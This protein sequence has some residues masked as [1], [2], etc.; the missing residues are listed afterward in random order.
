MMLDIANP[1]SW[2]AS[3]TPALFGIVFC[4]L[5]G[6]F[7]PPLR[8]IALLIVSVLMQS[9]VNY[10]NDYYDFIKGTDTTESNLEKDDAVLVYNHINPK[11]VLTVAIVLLAA[12]AAIGIAAA[13]GSGPLPYVIGVIGGLTVIFYSG[14]KTPISYLPLGE[15]LSGLVMG[16]G[17]PLAIGGVARL[18]SGMLLA[19][20]LTSIPFVIGIAMIMMT[21]NICDIERD[22]EAGRKTYPAKV[23]REAAKKKYI[24]LARYWQGTICV[25]CAVCMPK[26]TG[27]IGILLVLF[28]PFSLFKYLKTSPLT[29]ETRIEQMKTIVKTN[30]VANGLYILICACTVVLN[31][32]LV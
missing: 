30:W 3:I 25:F 10:F 17:I 22:L 6:V 19:M 23:G 11:S 31:H 4:M 7:L 8:A 29:Q 20:G 5:Q 24:T 1:R 14:G 2:V 12:A 32:F 9:A 28:V 21:N 27:I 15:I 18:K 16:M 13:W 26:L